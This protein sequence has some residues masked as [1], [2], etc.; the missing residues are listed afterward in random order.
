VRSGPNSR[1]NSPTR[2][3]VASPFRHTRVFRRNSSPPSQRSTVSRTP[4]PASARRS[5]DSR[6]LDGWN[7]GDTRSRRDEG[8]W[9]PQGRPPSGKAKVGPQAK[10]GPPAKAQLPPRFLKPKVVQEAAEPIT[11]QN[12]MSFQRSEASSMMLSDWSLEMEE[13]EK[14]AQERLGASPPSGPGIIHVSDSG[15]QWGPPPDS[16]HPA[17]RSAGPPN[18]PWNQGVPAIHQT[19]ITTTSAMEPPRQKFLYDPNNPMMPIRMPVGGDAV[20]GRVEPGG[21]HAAMGPRGPLLAGRG[22]VATHAP[23][24]LRFPISVPRFAP[25]PNMFPASIVPGVGH[26]YQPPFPRLP[27]QPP[28]MQGGPAWFDVYNT[29]IYG[30]GKVDINVIVKIVTADKKLKHLLQGG[31]TIVCNRWEHEVR[32]CRHEIMSSAWHLMKTD[33]FFVCEHEVDT[34]IWKTVYYQVMEMLKYCVQD[35]ENTTNE[36]RQLL[37]SQIMQLIEEGTDF[38]NQILKDLG[39]IYHLD[40]D[41]FLDVLEPRNLD[42]TGRLALIAAQKSLLYLGD[43]ARYKEQVNSTT[44]Y[45][46]A[47]QYYIKANCLDMR[48]GRPFNMLAILAKISNRKFEAVYYNI[49]LFHLKVVLKKTTKKD[50][51]RHT[52]ERME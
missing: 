25:H 46:R 15:P 45:G 32:E 29:A 14:S 19:V 42:K 44:N 16:H 35:T 50:K 36:T 38:Y 48:N 6:D 1:R 22:G 2:S 24:P 31:P 18:Q 41:R 12:Q 4:S 5:R 51:P 7:R 13:E 8:L 40:V 20:A 21:Y 39:E 10:A 30:T 47:R 37:K 23:A 34:Y 49:R 9:D 28:H 33:I 52:H 11:A 3:R 27:V 17:W 26:A 43:L